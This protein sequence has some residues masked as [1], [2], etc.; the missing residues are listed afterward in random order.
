[1]HPKSTDHVILLKSKYDSQITFYSDLM[2]ANGSTT[3]TFHYIPNIIKNI[4]CNEA[5]I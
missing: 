1:M 5:S 2:A 3:N 4:F